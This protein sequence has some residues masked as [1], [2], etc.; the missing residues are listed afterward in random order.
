MVF[1]EVVSEGAGLRILARWGNAV[2]RWSRVRIAIIGRGRCILLFVC[3]LKDVEV[4]VF[5]F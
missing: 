5:V 3:L 1:G 2:V 4:V